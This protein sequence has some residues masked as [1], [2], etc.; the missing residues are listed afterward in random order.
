M[1]EPDEMHERLALR[2]GVRAEHVTPEQLQKAGECLASLR[3]VD[4]GELLASQH[5]PLPY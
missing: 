1:Q 2:Y 3:P 4:L 5:R